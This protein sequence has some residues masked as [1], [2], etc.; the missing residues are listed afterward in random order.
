MRLRVK[1]NSI[2]CREATALVSRTLDDA[3]P[4]GG[5]LPRLLAHLAACAL[6]ARFRDQ[7]LFLRA[8]IARATAAVETEPQSHGLSND[9]RARIA[10]ALQGHGF[11]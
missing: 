5:L 10:L 6:C 9:A 1:G 7:L 4:R 3:P 8:A 2:S 11:G